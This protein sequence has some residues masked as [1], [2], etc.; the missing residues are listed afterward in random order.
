MAIAVLEAGV[1]LHLTAGEESALPHVALGWDAQNLL[2]Y[3]DR[4]RHGPD[5]LHRP[6]RLLGWRPRAGVRTRG[7]LPGSYDVDVTTNA[8]GLRG[9]TEVMRDKS[10]GVSRVAVFGCSQTFGTGVSDEETYS[11]RLDAALPNVQVLNFGVQG[12][13]TDQMLLYWKAE[14]ASFAPDVVIL[15]FAYYHTGRNVS[16]FRFYAKPRFELQDDGGLQL[17]GVPV[18]SP[19]SILRTVD[20]PRTLPLADRSVLLRWTWLRILRDRRAR[21]FVPGTAAW[22]LTTALI[23][24][25]AASVQAGGAQLILV[26]IEED[27]AGVDEA[28]AKLADEI[29]SRFVSVGQALEARHLSGS[30]LRLRGDPHWNAEGHRLIADVLSSYVRESKNRKKYEALNAQRVCRRA[31]L[32]HA[33]RP[34]GELRCSFHEGGS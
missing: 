2:A 30:Q 3:L 33:P 24:R 19:E 12:Y 27:G 17:V 11:A 6:D 22:R 8:H 25:F 10:A 34:S 20:L 21:D 26:H 18:P 31:A 4:A 23:K 1:R 32:A 28:L 9:S 29:G 7:V 14:G 13:G 5:A 16:R 15:A